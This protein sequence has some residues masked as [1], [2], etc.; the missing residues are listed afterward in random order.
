MIPRFINHEIR[1]ENHKDLYFIIKEAFAQK[2]L[3]EV[4]QRLTENGI[5]FALQ[6][7]ISEVI[8]DPQ[9]RANNYF[10][11]FDHPEHG[12]IEIPASPLA[13]SETP[14]TYRLPAPRF[15]QHTEETL[16]KDLITAG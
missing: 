6:Q 13:L 5:P 10:A 14:A 2:D 9:A 4:F 16:L 7:K 3:K 15:S 12:P 11:Q 8:H 1:L